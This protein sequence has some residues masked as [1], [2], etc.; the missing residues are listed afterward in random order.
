MT[1]AGQEQSE[2]RSRAE[3]GQKQGR[4]RAEA[5][6]E[7]LSLSTIFGQY[8][9]PCIVSW[10][11]AGQEYGGSRAGAKQE[12]GRSIARAGAGQKQWAIFG[13][14]PKNRIT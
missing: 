13:G 14:A 6:H 9:P 4:S 2:S 10:A 7:P 11:G 12:Q 1:G 3:A 5:G 8:Q